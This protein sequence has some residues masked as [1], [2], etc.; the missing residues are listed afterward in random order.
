VIAP[1]RETNIP[2]LQDA[3]RHVHGCESTFV[4]TVVVEERSEPKPSPEWHFT[5]YTIWCGEV[6]VFDLVGHAEVKRAYAWSRPV[7]GTDRRW[8]AVVPHLGPV[9]SPATAVRA[10]LAGEHR[11]STWEP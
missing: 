11:G 3:I 8:F 6:C 2:A 5:S 9:V 1:F 7:P 4:E 10:C